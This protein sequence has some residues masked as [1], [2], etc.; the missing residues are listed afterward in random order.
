[1]DDFPSTA[2]VTESIAQGVCMNEAFHDLRRIFESSITVGMVAQHFLSFD[3]DRDVGSVKEILSAKNYDFAGVRRNGVMTGYVDRNDLQKGTLDQY[4]RDFSKDRLL[5]EGEGLAKAVGLL[6]RREPVFVCRASVVWGI[7]TP[8]DMSQTAPRLWVLG[9][10][11]ILEA[12]IANWI[13][14]NLSK[15]EALSRLSPGRQKRLQESYEKLRASNLE[16][17]ELSCLQLAD[18]LK[19][20]GNERALLSRLEFSSKNQFRCFSK[21]V[22]RLRDR[23]YHPNAMGNENECFVE[24]LETILQME[25]FISQLNQISQEA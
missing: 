20:L 9:L 16:V 17:D 11:G 14:L 22:V 23:L 21:K 8:A 18:R 13:R 1:M 7:F 2:T 15:E 25:R 24:H 4:L 6:Q 3:D 12:T 19:F 10:V 5:E